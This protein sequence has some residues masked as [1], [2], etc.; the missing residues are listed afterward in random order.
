MKAAEGGPPA[1]QEQQANQQRQR[2]QQTNQ[3]RQIQSGIIWVQTKV[4]VSGL[5][6]VDGRQGGG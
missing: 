2:K 6:G 3:Q 1:T 5:A 4:H